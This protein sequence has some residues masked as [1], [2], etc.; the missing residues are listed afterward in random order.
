V[1]A[2]LDRLS[3][4]V[5]FLTTLLEK[6]VDFIA[7]DN[8]HATKF[9]I[10]ILAAVAE[11]E[12]D[13]ISKRTREALAAAKARGVRL[14]NYARIS[15]AKQEATRARYETVRKPIEATADMSAN[16]AAI[17]L[18]DRGVTPRLAAPGGPSRSCGLGGTWKLPKAPI[19]D[20]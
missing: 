15:K 1:V 2:K 6:K 8:P 19:L 18:N 14:G 12:R 7:V 20:P 16:A 17:Y 4:N 9:N 5:A 10:H 13:A 3:R 11:F